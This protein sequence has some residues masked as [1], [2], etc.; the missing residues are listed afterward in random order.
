MATEPISQDT[1]LSQL[2]TRGF[3][4][5]F[6]RTPLRDFWGK[7][8]SITGE[9]RDGNNGP[10]LVVLYN[11]DVHEVIESAEPYTAPIGQ[12]EVPQSTKARSKMG[13]LGA[14]IDRKINTGVDPTMPQEMAKG[15]GFLVGK[16]CHMKLT[17]G[18]MIWD[19][20]AKQ[21][22]P[23]DCWELLEYREDGQSATA[24]VGA[25]PSTVAKPVSAVQ[26]ALR[27]LE[28]KTDSQW[29]SE[30]FANAT[31]KADSALVNSIIA[32][33]FLAGMEAAGKVMKDGNGV[34]HV[35]P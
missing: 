8:T 32:K 34:Y 9:M 26:E 12:I 27:L 30:V 3:E 17:P 22:R 20:N 21:E 31:V 23:N 2:R 5:G 24:M 25:V 28:G 10:Y 19:G 1:I 11:F 33:T 29:H 18:H 6:Q 7:M 4:E 15:Q 13:Y 14:S 16:L 35:V